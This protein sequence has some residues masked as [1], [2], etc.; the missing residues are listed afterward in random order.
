MEQATE[1]GIGHKTWDG[2]WMANL[3]VAMVINDISW[4]PSGNMQT[5]SI[6]CL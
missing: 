3:A 4:T 6:L 5:T 2:R 1:Y